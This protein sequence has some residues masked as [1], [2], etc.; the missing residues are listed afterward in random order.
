MHP[1]TSELQKLK[2]QYLADLG[3]IELQYSTHPKDDSKQ[4]EQLKLRTKFLFTGYKEFLTDKDQSE[5]NRA[6][7]FEFFGSLVQGGAPREAMVCAAALEQ[8]TDDSEHKTTA[9]SQLV[10]KVCEDWGSNIHLSLQYAVIQYLTNFSN[11]GSETWV[12]II[13]TLF[14]KN[15]DVGYLS[16]NYYNILC[17]YQFFWYTGEEAS[18]YSLIVYAKETM[19]DKT[20]NLM[21][22]FTDSSA[23]SRIILKAVHVEDFI[24]VIKPGATTCFKADP[25]F[26]FLEKNYPQHVKEIIEKN[27]SGMVVKLAD[28]KDF[29]SIAYLKKNYGIDPFH[30]LIMH[31]DKQSPNPYFGTEL[32]SYLE[33]HFPEKV[34]SFIKRSAKVLVDNFL[35]N[36]DHVSLERMMSYPEFSADAIFPK[37]FKS[38][39]D[40]NGELKVNLT[41]IPLFQS[42]EKHNPESIRRYFSTL[43]KFTGQNLFAQS[44]SSNIYFAT[45]YNVD[46]YRF[47]DNPPVASLNLYY[48]QRA[49]TILSFISLQ[50]FP[51]A[52]AEYKRTLGKTGVELMLNNA[53][54][55]ISNNLHGLIKLLQSMVE[56]PDNAAVIYRKVVTV[57]A[58]YLLSIKTKD[59]AEEYIYKA[60]TSKLCDDTLLS[61]FVRR[62][63]DAGLIR[64][65]TPAEDKK[66]SPLAAPSTLTDLSVHP[67]DNPKLVGQPFRFL[68]NTN[69]SDSKLRQEV[70][71]ASVERKVNKC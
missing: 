54:I 44:A 68:G 8:K 43:G 5:K 25:W 64:S 3:K 24:P 14:Y 38:E 35:S 57:S 11:L 41:T 71:E 1:R 70:E 29:E 33:R 65:K 21:K 67:Q 52:I 66:H 30:T 28:N 42:L 16:T 4:L 31:H 53:P 69:D 19:A 6:D 2:N 7:Y 60:L 15:A 55:T 9:S 51:H 46:M 26:Q 39:S 20:L 23:E 18:T 22:I 49:K 37:I 45:Q 34:E 48:C 50:T 58:P 36:K 59:A 56:Q 17:K 63:F 27:F 62:E 10:D 32:F 12:P 61:Q 40:E 47:Y 13:K